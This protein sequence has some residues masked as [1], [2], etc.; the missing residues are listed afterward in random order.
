MRWKEYMTKKRNYDDAV[1]C[2]LGFGMNF[3]KVMFIP[4]VYD[5]YVTFG[6]WKSIKDV[7]A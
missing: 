5:R 1:I 2:W 4:T 3:G 7:L 6:E